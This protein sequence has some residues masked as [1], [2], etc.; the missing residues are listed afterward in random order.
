M[1]ESYKGSVAIIVILETTT[2]VKSMEYYYAATVVLMV[3]CGYTSHR[4]GK[5]NGIRTLLG[6]LEINSDDKGYIALRITED[7]FSIIK[8][9]SEG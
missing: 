6:F 4:I 2:E 1:L 7:D 5:G 9:K 3:G 8:E